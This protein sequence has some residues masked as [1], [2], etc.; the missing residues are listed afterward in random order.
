MSKFY[1]ENN[2]DKGDESVSPGWTSL[3]NI[4]KVTL[5][6]LFN[7]L[8][9][10]LLKLS[11]QVNSHYVQIKQPKNNNKYY[12]TQHVYGKMRQYS[13]SEQM[14]RR[15]IRN[16]ERVEEGVAEN[17]L[18]VM[19]SRGSKHKVEIWVMFIDNS[20]GKRIGKIKIITTWR[21]PGVSSK[22]MKIP[23][24][25]DIVEELGIYV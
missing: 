9:E 23:I 2:L 8:W 4:K 16:P 19:Q 18:A 14:V 21:Y 12:W 7:E 20:N 3:Y 15:I 1:D 10:I 17:T 24:P 5:Q 22:R 13:I 11:K 25:Q 6:Y